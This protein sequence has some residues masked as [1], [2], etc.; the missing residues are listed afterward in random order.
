MTFGQKTAK[1][2]IILEWLCTYPK[3]T[4]SEVQHKKLYTARKIDFTKIV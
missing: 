2:T 3:A 4:P 1:T